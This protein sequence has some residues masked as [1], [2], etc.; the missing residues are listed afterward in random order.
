MSA[1]IIYYAFD[2]NTFFFR[3]YEDGRALYM[4]VEGDARDRKDWVI[5]YLQENNFRVYTGFYH[6]DGNK[7]SFD[8]EASAGFLV[9]KSDI[10]L[11]GDISGHV[12]SIQTKRG[13]QV[14]IKPFLRSPGFEWKNARH[15]PNPAGLLDL[16]LP[17][18]E[19][20][21]NTLGE[22]KV[23]Y[24]DSEYVEDGDSTFT[25]IL[26]NFLKAAGTELSGATWKAGEKWQIVAGDKSYDL[27]VEDRRRYFVN[28]EI[29]K[30]FN[31][32]LES[33]GSRQ[34]FFYFTD[35]EDFDCG[36]CYFLT[37]KEQGLR[38]MEFLNDPPFYSYH[39]FK[40][41]YYNRVI[42]MSFVDGS[43]QKKVEYFKRLVPDI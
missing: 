36:D 41:H 11:N 23:F 37:D 28:N 1:N 31:A 15:K 30:D 35:I 21:Q 9:Y 13:G 32:I 14:T 25:G 5:E 26:N 22:D 6:T 40:Q 29:V 34:R 42:N 38:Y 16:R 27:H 43:A 17:T 2:K 3:F 4:Q 19:Q 10:L 33:A 24:I 18:F 39:D 12:Y 8:I 20:L 7:L